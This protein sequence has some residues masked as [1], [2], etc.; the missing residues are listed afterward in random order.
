MRSLVLPLLAS[1]TLSVSASAQTAP[2]DTTSKKSKVVYE[3][4]NPRVLFGNEGH[5]RLDNST[6]DPKVQF[7]L[8]SIGEPVD[9]NAANIKGLRQLTFGGENL[10][11]NFSSTG[12]D[13]FFE[14]RKLEGITCAQVFK[15]AIDGSAARRISAGRGRSV[16][17]VE[18]ALGDRFIYSS[19][20]ASINGNCP[21]DFDSSIARGIA[22]NGL[23]E[24]YIADSV[25]N[26]MHAL[27]SDG[28]FYDGQPQVSPDNS[29]VLFTS[30]RSGDVDLF[31]LNV[32]SRELTQLT[33]D[34]GYDGNARFSPDGKHIVFAASRPFGD[35]LK[36]Y[37]RNLL[38]GAAS[39][40]GTEIYMMNS[41]GSNI[42]QITSN[43]AT[44]TNPTFSPDGS[45]IVF[46]SNMHD[47]SRKD[48]DLFAVEHASGGEPWAVLSS[49]AI[50]DQPTFSRDGKKLA[51]VSTRNAQP[52]GTNIF[53][54]DW[55]E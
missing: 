5:E 50:E 4:K 22:M 8:K 40:V 49:P 20:H 48:F 32:K 24:L 17:G 13:L 35:A 33:Q 12:N 30:T 36:R 31:L 2:Q 10:H 19:T 1:F 51:F 46:S 7:G 23:Y 15:L 26:V 42:R 41:D 34:E 39:L 44:N 47:A 43:G 37:R 14:A 25:G 27:T 53:V 52:G 16:N 11:P 3:L 54:A 55:K 9:M 18:N 6:V 21:P 28:R 38:E 29:S 45:K